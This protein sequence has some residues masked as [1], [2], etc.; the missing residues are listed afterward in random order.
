[1][2]SCKEGEGVAHDCLKAAGKN[3]RVLSHHLKERER[4][5]GVG[6]ELLARLTSIRE[7]RRGSTHW[8]GAVVS[9]VLRKGSSQLVVSMSVIEINNGHV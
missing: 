2:R 7:R 9:T 5:S 3:D 4:R 6:E 1:M 8:F